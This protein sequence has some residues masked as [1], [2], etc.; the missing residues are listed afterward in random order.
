MAGEVW[1]LLWLGV[2]CGKLFWLCCNG[3]VNFSGLDVQVFW[4]LVP[5]SGSKL[6]AFFLDFSV[7]CPNIACIYKLWRLVIKNMTIDDVSSF[8]LLLLNLWH[9]VMI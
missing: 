1:Y 4:G 2:G 6:L 7:G 3:V 8:F 5:R 9:L